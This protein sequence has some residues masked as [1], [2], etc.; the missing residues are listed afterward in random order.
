MPVTL[1]P[2]DDL[3]TLRDWLR[4]G[5]SAFTQA[6][7]SYGHGTATAFDEAAFLLLSVLHLPIDSLDPWLDCRLTGPERARIHAVFTQRIATRKPASYLV[8]AAYIQGRQFYVDERVIVP[9]S[10]IGELLV[11]DRL[12]AVCD[13]GPPPRTVLDLCTGSGCLAILAA[14]A[15]PSA[16]IDAAD[17]ST[18][19]LA[20]AARNVAD[21][22]LGQRIELI[23][24]DLFAALHGRRYDLIISNPPYVT[25]D[26]VRAFPPEYRAEPTLAHLSGHD[27]LDHVRQI[28]A[29]A[30]QY[31]TA[32]ATLVVEI[33]QGRNRLEAAFQHLPFF[34]LDTETS[35][36][37]V[38]ALKR[39]DFD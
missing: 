5:V 33:G 22:D 9:R 29:E 24:S 15:F 36:G 25:A 37:E 26:A 30:P 17:I 12:M 18:D 10:F 38:F 35:E 14:E 34:W 6:G 4:Y 16:R 28:L 20:V 32:N 3:L 21:Y 27:G 23:A 13:D 1:D 31:L 19:A 11:S 39:S 7:L 2:T 8:N